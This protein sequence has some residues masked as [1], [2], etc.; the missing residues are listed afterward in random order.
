MRELKIKDWQVWGE[1]HNIYWFNTCYF[2]GV[3][4]NIRDYLGYGPSQ[5]VFEQDHNIQTVYFSRLEWDNVGK[6]FLQEILKD[7]DRL[8][9][10][11][12]MINK[13]SDVLFSFS[14]KLKKI[15]VEKLTKSDQLKLLINYHKRHHTQWSISQV[16]NVLELGSS[17]LTDYLKVWLAKQNIS[18]EKQIKT[19]Q[20]L[21]TPVDL[22]EAQKEER[23]MLK[24]AQKRN[25]VK[26]LKKHWQKYSWLQ[27]GWTGPS[28]KLEYF[29]KNHRALYQEG[30]ARQILADILAKEKKLIFDKKRVIKDLKI[31]REVLAIFELFEKLLF[32]KTYRLDVLYF[33]YEA[34]QPL[35]KKIAK[36][37]SLSLGQIYALYMDWL[38]E[39]MRKDNF[40][41]D[42]INEIA[43]YSVWYFDGAKDYLLIGDEA[44]NFIQPVKKSLPAVSD[45]KE[46]KGESAFPGKVKGRVIIVNTAKDMERF[47]KGDILVSNITDPSLLSAMK[48]AKAFVTN[49]GG[50][51]C[52]AAIVARELG[53]P[54]VVGTKIATKVLK[55]GDLVEVDA[56]KGIVRKIN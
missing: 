27:F 42:K 37:N 46:L 4:R 45:I 7:P 52:H 33:S 31:P 34:V 19:F 53:T 32:S 10:L 20:I 26:E 5:F 9:N 30:K 56:E 3:T 49:M 47:S 21:I 2:A 11:I 6:K 50:L 14:K 44:K 36:E 51:T 40:D 12:S 22:S 15:D 55:D 29:I 48:K 54:C 35:L 18:A 39:M 23:V 17:L 1:W 38:I 28:L 24:L 13:A 41:V 25:P 8:G 43:K 16:P